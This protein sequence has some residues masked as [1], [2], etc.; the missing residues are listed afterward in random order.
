MMQVG[1]AA[2]I[3]VPVTLLVEHT[4][5]K[6]VS[7]IRAAVDVETRIIAPRIRVTD[8]VQKGVEFDDR[9]L[10]RRLAHP[11]QNRD[12]GLERCFEVLDHR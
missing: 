8:L 3:A 6:T 10:A 2:W 9:L 1:L 7:L 5:A 12:V 4:D 11:A